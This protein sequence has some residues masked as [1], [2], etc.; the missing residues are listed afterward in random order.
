VCHICRY[1][2]IPEAYESL[3][4]AL[5]VYEYKRYSLKRGRQHVTHLVFTAAARAKEQFG[6]L[7]L[8]AAQ[9]IARY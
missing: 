1:D 6:P 8:H 9:V 4:E 5:R 2:F 7:S 3:D